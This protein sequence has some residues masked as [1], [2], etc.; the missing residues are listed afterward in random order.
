ML[1]KLPGHA[2][3]PVNAVGT[4]VVIHIIAPV[5]TVPDQRRHSHVLHGRPFHLYKHAVIGFKIL[6]LHF[7][8]GFHACGEPVRYRVGNGQGRIGHI[9]ILREIELVFVPGIDGPVTQVPGVAQYQVQVI[10]I[11]GIPSGIPGAKRKILPGNAGSHLPNAAVR[12]TIQPFRHVLAGPSGGKGKGPVPVRGRDH[13][14]L[15]F[16]Q[17]GYGPGGDFF[18]PAN[19]SCHHSAAQGCRS[20]LHCGVINLHKDVSN[21]S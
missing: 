16:R 9:V 18:P 7:H 17:G 11:G 2:Q 13:G 19:V 5:V 14:L 8:L 10:I 4:V 15:H 1:R 3:A 6:M 20:Y 12:Q 21:T